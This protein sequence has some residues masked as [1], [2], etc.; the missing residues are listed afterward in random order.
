MFD[1]KASDD[2]ELAIDT[3]G[4]NDKIGRL[5]HFPDFEVPEHLSLDTIKQL[6][7]DGKL[8]PSTTNVIGVRSAPHLINWAARVVAEET[9]EMAIAKNDFFTRARAN[10]YGAIDY[11]KEAP[12]R[13]R[14]FAGV[15]GSN[16]HFACE[17]I[18][19]GEDIS[20]MVFSDFERKAVD[21]WKKWVDTF[22]PEFIHLEATSFGKTS[23]GLWFGGT[24]DF[25]AKINDKLVV[26]DYKCVVDDTKIMMENGSYKQAI[27]IQVGDRVV[28]WSEENSLHVQEVSYAGDNGYHETITVTTIDGHKLTTTLNHPYLVNRAG[29][30]DWVNAEDIKIGDTVFAA[31]GWNHSPER[32]EEEWPFRHNLSPYHLGTLWAIRNY[33]LDNWRE[34][35][36]ITLP[37][38]SREGLRE[39]LHLIGFHFNKA[40]QLNTRK[41]LAKIARKNKLSI[42]Q[43]LD[44]F[45]TTN[46]PDFLYGAP[47]D[48]VMG[49]LTG[50][51]EVFVNKDF[52]KEE[53]VVVF[54]RTEALR[55]L[56]Q[57]YYNYGKTATILKDPKSGLEYLKAPFEDTE[58][59]FNFGSEPTRVA[60]IQLNP[61]PQHTVAIEVGGK[62]GS[63][64]HITNG[65]ITHNTNRSGLHIDIALQLAAN[66][67]CE[68]LC[69][70]N[71]TLEPM[72][73]VEA[74]YGLH[75]SPKGASMVE[76]DIS[77]KIWQV[78]EHLRGAWDFHAFEG[79]RDSS[80]GVFLRKIKGLSEI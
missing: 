29:S 74:A 9:I 58:S 64:T 3:S 62:N 35:H 55:N 6:V 54:R 2:P 47:R 38:I 16:V 32:Q 39:E 63:H 76:I 43:V 26:G 69:S 21:E 61:T 5:Y 67:R 59:T 70:D 49:F 65:L 50:V 41:G 33:G 42:E 30:L 79:K 78:F 57:L 23:E 45:D 72:P 46:L 77:D 8:I 13:Q 60:S 31:S 53:M 52:S 73:K 19:R 36:L 48:F 25:I 24:S 51:Q 14:D 4:I 75:V 12:N 56:Q 66:S 18:A 15:Q 40:G 34:D 44:L 37:K 28:A 68:F 10:K 71:K 20:H 27:D 7:R 1:K 11:F 17:L 80:K 22:Q